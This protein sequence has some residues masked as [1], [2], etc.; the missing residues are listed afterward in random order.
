MIKLKQSIFAT[1][2]LRVA[3][4]VAVNNYSNFEN[5]NSINPVQIGKLVI[6]NHIAYQFKQTVNVVSQELFVSRQ[7]DIE[8]YILGLQTLRALA[9][10]VY[11]YCNKDI[12]YSNAALAMVSPTDVDDLTY[13]PDFPTFVYVPEVGIVTSEEAEAKCASYG[14]RLP[15]IHTK[16]ER[17]TLMQYLMSKG[18]DYCHAGIKMDLISGYMRY[19]HTGLP[20]WKGDHYYANVTSMPNSSWHLDDILDLPGGHFFYNADGGLYV[21]YIENKPIQKGIAN[22]GSYYNQKKDGAYINLWIN[23]VRGK[24]VCSPR[25][26]GPKYDFLYK[27]HDRANNLQYLTVGI[28]EPKLDKRVEFTMTTPSP[29]SVLKE[30]LG[31][32]Q[33]YKV[34]LGQ[35]TDSA[36][37]NFANETVV[38]EKPPVRRS[39]DLSKWDESIDSL[40]KDTAYRLEDAAEEY[41]SRVVSTLDLVDISMQ[42]KTV[43]GDSVQERTTK[44]WVKVVFSTGI[45]SKKTLA[46]LIRY[47]P[48]LGATARVTKAALKLKQLKEL[49]QG[50][51]HD[52]IGMN[53]ILTVLKD[54]SVPL[55]RLRLTPG[56]V[57][58]KVITL[59]KLLDVFKDTQ[60]LP[61][62][63]VLTTLT[64]VNGIMDRIM[65][66]M[67]HSHRVL[68][69]IV[70][71]SLSKTT[72]P[73]ALPTEALMDVQGV[74][75]KG[76]VKANINQDY[77]QMQSYI[78]IDPV[79]ETK[80]MLLV[81]ATAMAQENLELIKMMPIPYFSQDRAYYPILESEFIVL[82]QPSLVYQTIS[83]TE[84]ESCL[85]GK[86]YINSMSK[87]VDSPV[88]GVAQLYEKY[89]NACDYSHHV[90][91][92]M[93]VMS[94]APDGIIYSFHGTYMGQLHCHDGLLTS[95][96]VTMTGVGS[97][98]VPTSCVLSVSD[99]SK[100][101]L[102]VKGIP[103]H[104]F[105]E[106]IVDLQLASNS[107]LKVSNDIPVPR[108]VVETNLWGPLDQQVSEIRVMSDKNH[109][110]FISLE[111]RFWGGVAGLILMLMLMLMCLQVLWRH[112]TRA[113]QNMEIIVNRISEDQNFRD[114][115]GRMRAT[116]NFLRETV[117]LDRLSLPSMSPNRGIVARPL[118][119]ARL[120]RNLSGSPQH[121]GHACGA[122]SSRCLSEQSLA[123]GSNLFNTIVVEA[124]Y[125]RDAYVQM[126]PLPATRHEMEELENLIEHAESIV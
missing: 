102:Q 24:V 101:L 57:D 87:S 6:K 2:V 12:K 72:S 69:D 120:G 39:I 47:F 79:D 31:S 4:V 61:R 15:E 108:V 85:N 48:R 42:G 17:L 63:M 5:A 126:N 40:C 33:A 125:D 10:Q 74:L 64:N 109:R 73:Y 9:N 41:Y 117:A 94:A 43:N 23:E 88:C 123:Q 119:R 89:L 81:D 55:N 45:K 121:Q 116:V 122:Q 104:H 35:G 67:E 83:P 84:A 65:Q 21:Q 111:T 8:P 13:D 38:P 53:L 75:S 20:I 36:A 92:G 3:C 19:T 25:Y 34:P 76:K 100:S 52:V 30:W 98:Y 32:N 49:E 1:I 70:H 99:G 27:P 60:V 71:K 44:P 96:P 51:V 54:Y 11:E 112:D 66:S 113:R 28:Y 58:N 95:D 97:M 91:N 78:F 7:L 115:F 105:T 56:K 46:K 103:T 93:F 14:M 82:N 59:R 18:I 106:G 29:Y 26:S 62:V 124:N 114:E 90:S 86:C 110:A 37:G 22:V 16:V 68:I 80:L 118:P 77:S 50:M 107:L